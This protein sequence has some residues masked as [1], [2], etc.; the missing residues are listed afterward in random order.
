MKASYST[1]LDNL[2]V[3][4][5]LAICCGSSEEPTDH[6]ETP[7]KSD[8]TCMKHEICMSTCAYVTGFA[9]KG[10]KHI[11]FCALQVHNLFIKIL[12]KLKL[13]PEDEI[14][15]TRYRCVL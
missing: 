13:S 7:L 12:K 6:D 3:M 5:L 14:F 15:S 2:I 10:L 11:Q 8:L 9:K 4:P 1:G